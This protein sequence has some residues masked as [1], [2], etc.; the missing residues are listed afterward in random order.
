MFE[1][2]PR[3]LWLFVAALTLSQQT[4]TAQDAE[5]RPN[6]LLISIDD[7]NDWVGPLSGHPQ[8]KTP[9][10]DRLARRG[11]TFTNAHC[12]VPVCS[13]SRTSLMT[14]KQP[15]RS[16]VYTNG[17]S[18]FDLNGKFK[19][20]PEHFAAAGYKTLGAGKLFHGS[21]GKYAKFFDEYGP[22]SGNQG[23]PFTKEELDTLKQNPVHVVNRGPGK[24]Q[25]TLPLNRM[26]DDRRTGESRNNTFDWGP[27]D[28]T[29]A[30]MPDGQVAAWAVK[31]LK[32]DFK[33]PFFL[34]VGFYR[35]H[36]PLFAPRRHFEEFP[37]DE[38]KLPATREDDLEDLPAYARRLAILP[39]TAG[40]HATVVKYEQ[41]NEAA[42]AY[43]ACVR[44]VDDLVGQVVDA[45]EASPY[46][47]NTWIVL[48]SD[49]GYHLGEKQHWG[50]F[51]TWQEATRVPLIIVPPQKLASQFATGRSCAEPISLIDLYPTLIDLCDLNRPKHEL[52]G[53]SLRGQL[54]DPAKQ[55]L[56][57]AIT[58]VGRGTY[59]LRSLNHRYTRYFDGTEELYDL[60]A[61]PN[62]WQ[63]IAEREES[64]S[65][66]N[67]LGKFLPPDE[68]VKR[69]VRN[70]RWKAVFFHDE[71]REPLLF[72]LT[73]G[74]GSGG[75]IGETRSTAKQHPQV[76]REIK[77]LLDKKASAGKHVILPARE[78]KRDESR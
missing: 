75:G 60:E 74:T 43:L 9:H 29:D 3:R 19:T 68:D 46:A 31:Q 63:N 64:K 45:L 32:R 73:G 65:L 41:W 67:Q 52:D 33:E 49:H 36:Q 55:R 6:V 51:T 69:F 13:P 71:S 48:F 24:L 25:A 10:L 34:G 62:E 28:V 70:G 53:E 22:G 42:R 39:L 26:P 57:P 59:T 76:L 66:I 23:G 58:T 50:K 61:D 54:I 2:N 7:L 8:T 14:G 35:P 16:G 40:R 37:A 15:F 11:V 27:V 30:E 72:E 78:S 1:Q 47:E 4:I 5:G 56:H 21:G 77:R 38:T 17:D 44:F 18:V 20:L 12:N